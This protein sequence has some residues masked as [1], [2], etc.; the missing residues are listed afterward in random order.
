MFDVK[1]DAVARRLVLRLSGFWSDRTMTE[2]EQAL[3]RTL[4]SAKRQFNDYETV[5]DASAFTVQSAAISARFGAL[6]AS[7]SANRHGRVAIVVASTL[8][9]LQVE[10]SMGKSNVRAFLDRSAADQWLAEGN[11]APK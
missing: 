10:R 6:M 1:F 7:L 9:K 4:A 11:Q 2:F 8:N 5:S 3:E